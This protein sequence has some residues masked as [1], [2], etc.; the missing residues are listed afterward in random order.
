MKENSDKTRKLGSGENYRFFVD[1]EV[2]DFSFSRM[3]K[4]PRITLD[5]FAKVS[6]SYDRLS[7][8]ASVKSAFERFLASNP[9]KEAIRVAF[10]REG[11]GYDINLGRI[12]PKDF[13]T[14]DNLPKNVIF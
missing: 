2:I 6:D 13:R 4:Y 9:Y 14:T 7:I 3:G 5:V 10:S 1:R 11:F 8:H 12:N